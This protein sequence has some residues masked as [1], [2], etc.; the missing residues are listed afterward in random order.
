MGIPTSIANPRITRN[1]KYQDSSVCS[2]AKLPMTITTRA[3]KEA[4][5]SRRSSLRESCDLNPV[6]S[7]AFIVLL[8]GLLD[9][10]ANAAS[11]RDPDKSIRASVDTDEILARGTSPD[12]DCYICTDGSRADSECSKPAVLKAFYSNLSNLFPIPRK[13]IPPWVCCDWIR[14]VAGGVF[15]N[16]GNGVVGD[17][18]V[19]GDRSSFGVP[20]PGSLHEACRFAVAENKNGSV[21]QEFESGSFDYVVVATRGMFVLQY[22]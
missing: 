3:A 17:R 15:N 18:I 6:N 13:R 2:T 21:L 5:F 9:K 22:R 19:R 7:K 1:W 20:S 8:I 12:V 10:V 4:N 16:L 11:R 14:E